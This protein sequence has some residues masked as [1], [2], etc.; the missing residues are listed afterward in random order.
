MKR[1]LFKKIVENVCKGS[2]LVPTDI[3]VVVNDIPKDNWGI[4]GGL[5]ASEVDLG[6]NKS[7][8]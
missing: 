2:K 1:D 4:R 5:M 6:V 3:F 8:K 7:A